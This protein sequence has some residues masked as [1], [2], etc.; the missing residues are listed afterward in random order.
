MIEPKKYQVEVVDKFLGK[1]W[2]IIGDSMGVGKTLEAVLLD[3]AERKA[4]PDP[5]KPYRTL[6]ICQKGGLSVWKWH[7]EDQGVSADR[8]LVI[9]PRDR[10]PFDHELALGARNYDYYIVHWNVLVRLDH[11]NTVALGGKRVVWDHVIADEVHLAKNRDALRT[12]ELK[13][14]RTKKKTGASGTPADDKPQ[15]FWSVLHWCD[16][17]TYSSYWRFYD[18][19]LNWHTHPENGYRV[20]DGVKNMDK[21]HREIGPNYIRRKLT[22]VV[23][24]MPPKT[25]GEIRV[26]ISARQ[27][28]DYDA[29]HKYQTAQVGEAK[30]ELLVAYKIAMYMRLQQ[31]T[32]GTVLEVDWSRY[33]AFWE[34]HK[35]TP[36]AAL[37][38][39]KPTGPDIILG[40]PSPKLDAVMEKVEEAMEE[41]ENIVVFSQFKAVVNLVEAR[42]LKKKIPVSKY[43]G[44]ITSQAVRDAAVADFQSKKTRVFAGTIGAAGTTITLTAA[45]TLLFT[46]RAWNPSVNEQAED[47]IWRMNQPNACQI[48]DII[49]DDTIDDERL[50][51][52]WKKAR[53]VHEVVNV[54]HHLKG[55]V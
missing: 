21:F 6:I 1:E 22:E 13:K 43:T 45:H 2:N 3:L 40:E 23:D 15:D 36:V 17:K 30:Q 31:M 16:S 9:D 39:R 44:A 5:K 34:K 32:L 27:R 19:Y 50:K 41:N 14:I 51:K 33:K 10:A 24:D 37:P 47:R 11:L 12:K 26:D 4:R 52:I 54:P 38:K 28:K 18:T 25:R 20:V 46:D 8:I 7:L 29:M 48:W 35:D 49:A 42:C 55:L 53:W